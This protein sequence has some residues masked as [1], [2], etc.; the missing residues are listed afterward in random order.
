MWHGQHAFKVWLLV[1]ISIRALT[2]WHGQ[3]ASKFD[4]WILLVRI[5][6]RALTTR[7]G[8]QAFK[9]WLLARISIKDLTTW[10]GRSQCAQHPVFAADVQDC[11]GLRM[12]WWRKSRIS[13]IPQFEHKVWS[14]DNHKI[15][16][17]YHSL[18]YNIV[19][20]ST[21]KSDTLR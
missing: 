16:F 18:S 7:H 13:S 3:Q 1:I 14:K 21:T 20:H 12:G 6:I 9:V 11:A 8:Q 15:P 4:F 17:T 2:T 5:S 10:H 19:Q